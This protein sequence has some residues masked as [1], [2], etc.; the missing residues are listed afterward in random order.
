VMSGVI[1][2]SKNETDLSVRTTYER[3]YTL[4]NNL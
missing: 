3:K 4:T 2:V 1:A